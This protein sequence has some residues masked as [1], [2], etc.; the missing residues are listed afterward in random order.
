MPTIV[1]KLNYMIEKEKLKIKR[2]NLTPTP[3]DN[4]GN[5]LKRSKSIPASA[6]LSAKEEKRP[7]R[8]TRKSLLLSQLEVK[9]ATEALEPAGRLITRSKSRA[10]TPRRS[11]S[12]Y[13]DE[14]DHAGEAT[15]AG[16]A[17]EAI[18][19]GAATKAIEAAEGL[20]THSSSPQTGDIFDESVPAEDWF[21]DPDDLNSHASG[22]NEHPAFLDHSYCTAISTGDHANPVDPKAEARRAI[23]A[24][25]HDYAKVGTNAGASLKLN[26]KL[27]GKPHSPFQSNAACSTGLTQLKKLRLRRIHGPEGEEYQVRTCMTAECVIS[28]TKS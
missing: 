5:L 7:V 14:T 8:L 22:K 17:T 4:E 18:E 9:E 26:F 21:D 6:K 16:T 27:A 25:D 1:R 24:N 23:V 12:S 10:Y 13:V 2:K 20:I 28:G 15:E 19:A 3:D 11:R